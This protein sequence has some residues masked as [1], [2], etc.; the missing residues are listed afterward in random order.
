MSERNNDLLVADIVESCR[1]IF[2]Y[3]DGLSFEQFQS[4]DK[5]LDAVMRNFEI[6]GE[7]A[8]RLPDSF[9]AAHPEIE[10]QRLRGFR[11]RIVHAYFGVDCSILWQI[12]ETYLPQLLAAL[13]EAPPAPSIAET[14][15]RT[16]KNP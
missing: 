15:P 6:I 16:P 1:K 11:N 2:R 14:P 13:E 3:T 5:T 7:A 8:S 9:R 12:K 4:D 10:W